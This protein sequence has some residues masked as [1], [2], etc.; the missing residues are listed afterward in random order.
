MVVFTVN[1]S[2]VI[3]DLG[4]ASLALHLDLVSSHST[5]RIIRSEWRQLYVRG[6]RSGPA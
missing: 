4:L 3:Y 5:Q 6:P 1:F 2:V